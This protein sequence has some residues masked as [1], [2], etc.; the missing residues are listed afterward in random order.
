[1]PSE[2]LS[3]LDRRDFLGGLSLTAAAAFSLTVPA[4]VAARVTDGQ[5]DAVQTVASPDGSIEVTVDA[6]DGPLTY[7][8]SHDGTT[9]VGESTLG[10]EFQN[11]PAFRDGLTVT[12]SERSTTDET[13]TPVW[14]QYDEIR[15]NHEELRIGLEESSSPGRSLTLAIRAFDDGVAFR[16]VFPEDSGFGDF[17]LTAER[18]QFAFEGDH[19]SWWIRNDYNSYEYAYR[20]TPLSEVGS[21]SSFDGA[22]TPITMRTDEDRYLSVHEAD[23]LDYAAMGLEPTETAT[24]LE[25]DLAPLPDGTKVTA[26]APHRTPWRTIQIADRPGALIESNLVL[27]CNEPLDPEHFPQGTDWIEPGKFIGIWWLMITGRANWQYRG[28]NEGN[29]AAQTERM[30]QYMDFASEHDIR[31]VLVEGWNVG[32]DSYPGSGDTMDFD[33][34]YEDFD[35]EAVLEYGQSL[36][37]PVE[38]TAHN[39]TSGNITNYESQLAEEPNHFATY[40]D[41]GIHSIKTGYVADSGVSIEEVSHNHHCQPLVNHHHLVYREAAANRQML[42]VHE[43]VKPTGERRRFPNVMTKEGVLGQEYDSFGYVD[44]SHHV[45]FPFTRMLGGPVEYT[46]GIFDMDSGSGGIETTRAK[47]LAMYP[48]YLSGLHMVADLPSSY[49]ADQPATLAVGGVGQAEFADRGSL[50]TK[51]SWGHAQGER[52]VPVDRSNGSDGSRLTWTVEDVPEAGEYDVHVRYANGTG[53]EQTLTVVAGDT[54]TQVSFTAT[55][56]WDVWDSV[57]TTVSLEGGDNT[58]AVKLATGDSGRVNVDAIAVSQPGEAMPEPETDP[59]RGPTV[60]AFQFVED[61]PA[62]GWDDTRVVDSA[63]GDYMATA[64]RKDDEWYLGVMAGAD[65]RVLDVPLEFLG[66]GQY[67]AELYNDGIDATFDTNLRD[68]RIDEV[69]VDADTTVLVSMIESGGMAVRLR[70]ADEDEVAELSSY[71]RPTQEVTASIE[72]EALTDQPVA[73]VTAENEGSNIG[74]TE[75]ELLVDGEVVEFRNVRA[76]PESARTISFG[77]RFT[78]EGTYEVEIRTTDGTTVGSESVTVIQPESVNGLLDPFGD[79]DGPGGYRYPTGAAFRGGAFDLR[80]FGVSTTPDRYRFSFQV[81]N[82]YDALED[83]RGFSPHMFVVWIH[84]PGAD[85]GRTSARDDLGANVDFERSWH[86]RLEASGFTKSAIAADGS[87]LV[88]ASSV[89]TEVDIEENTVTVSAPSSAFESDASA[90]SVVAG[91]HAEAD[92]RLRAVEADATD[93]TFGGADPVENAPRLSDML[94]TPRIDQA[95]AMA[96]SADERASL[97]FVPLGDGSNDGSSS[98]GS[99]DGPGFGI[100]SGALGTAGGIAYGIRS[101]ADRTDENDDK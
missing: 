9:V 31:S 54:E 91:V 12:G 2:H 66:S 52:Y 100:V 63:I 90:L 62:A 38:M 34:S 67:V 68:V 17:V 36:E 81:D 99:G 73:T 77:H 26:S 80:F 33:Q 93:A 94:T 44:P 97:P 57:S 72:T 6:A 23:L 28:P 101:L 41:R 29:H 85:G 65:A 87:T 92:G 40:D 24:T 69:L 89:T 47:Q 98:S 20:E 51:A 49:L 84:D 7:T 13:W 39:E 43:P 22:H 48:T 83:S 35:W 18:T 46:P 88:D 21:G 4:G 50:A 25:T 19:T 16:Y 78:D 45:T 96:Y 42:E 79:D 37:P 60:D 58:V 8:V 86:Y 64:R 15:D 55:D 1:V 27:N 30:K 95:D 53:D 71:E 82:L 70:P 56:N 11:Q 5:D 10:F 14:D 75:I 59:I 61:V 3:H 76:E 32:W 74:G